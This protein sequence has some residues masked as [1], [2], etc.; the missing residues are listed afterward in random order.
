MATIDLRFLWMQLKSIIGSHFANYDE[1]TK[2]A[3]LIFNNKI[4]PI[5]HSLN[6]IEDLPKR[7]DEMY[8][9]NTFGK[10]VFKHV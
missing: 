3:D 6:K 10:I 4:K 7:M 5:I 2:A 9:G 1:A 8:A